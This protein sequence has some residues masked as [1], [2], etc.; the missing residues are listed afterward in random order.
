MKILKKYSMWLDDRQL[1]ILKRYLPTVQVE[2]PP[3]WYQFWRQE[4]T[5]FEALI[6][7]LINY[8]IWQL[9]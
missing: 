7:S 4:F 2:V 1:F 6:L 3:K 5:F 8:F 9:I